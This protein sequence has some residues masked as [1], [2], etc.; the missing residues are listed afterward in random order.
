MTGRRLIPPDRAFAAR[1]HLGDHRPGRK[2]Q[3]ELGRYLLRLTVRDLA[4]DSAIGQDGA[5]VA[6]H[7]SGITDLEAAARVAAARAG[8]KQA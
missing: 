1:Y 5:A 7:L 8:L 3:F 4:S 6:A 2:R